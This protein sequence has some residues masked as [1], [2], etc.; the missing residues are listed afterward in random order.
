[1]AQRF[2]NPEFFGQ[3]GRPLVST[4]LQQF[5]GDFAERGVT[6]P[7][8][9]LEENDYFKAV[10]Q[11]GASQNGFPPRLHDV[12]YGIAAVGNEAGKDRLLFAAAFEPA[13]AG[14]LSQTATCAELALQF[15][16]AAPALFE[17][18]VRETQILARSSFLVFGSSEPVPPTTPFAQPT[19]EQLRLF[20]ADVDEWVAEEYRGEDRATSIE[21]YAM[22]DEHLFL[23]RIGD[24][25]TRHAVVRGNS[26]GYDHFR[27]A[28]D[29]V[30][31]YSP[32]R[33]EIRVNG[34]G[35]KK[36]RMLRETFGRRFF[37]QPERFSV[38]N[39]FTLAPLVRLGAAAL[40]VTPNTGIER[41]I[42][43]ELVQETDG[44]SPV[45]MQLQ[46]PDLFDFSERESTR[47][48]WPK[49]RVICA[50][51]DVYFSGQQTPRQFV[52]REGNGLRQVRDSDATAL[53]RWMTDKGFRRTQPTEGLGR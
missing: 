41:I 28:R 42:L 22:G 44:D 40:E 6:I 12:L 39:P 32:A 15:Y 2:S 36:I 3:L 29:L 45:K 51:F 53:Y 1:M 47:L 30:V 33:D 20:K 46:G 50:G 19:V 48:F 9:E 23:L 52:L 26:F 14:R 18:K 8:G 31:T 13:L 25:F 4:L 37:G 35:T 49:C 24:S 11:L 16:L 17:K 10:A 7:N 34:K 43:T 38:Q 27:P 21:Y 5:A